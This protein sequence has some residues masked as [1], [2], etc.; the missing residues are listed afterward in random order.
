ML[1]VIPS[2]LTV[3]LGIMLIGILPSDILSIEGYNN[4]VSLLYAVILV[5]FVRIVFKNGLYFRISLALVIYV[6]LTTL[7]SRINQILGGIVAQQT[8]GELLIQTIPAMPFIL[9][10]IIYIVNSIQQP[11]TLLIDET[12]QVSKGNLKVQDVNL[13]KYGK[14][15]I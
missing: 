13:D 2:I 9:V 14:E 4:Y 3:L 8:I 5:I 10:M 7:T 1:L 6:T 12:E 15:F 11:L